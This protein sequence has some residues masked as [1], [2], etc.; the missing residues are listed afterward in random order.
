MF[1]LFLPQKPLRA[2]RL[3]EI[4]FVFI[5]RKGAETAEKY[6]VYFVFT[7]NTFARFA[8][9]REKIVFLF[10]ARICNLLL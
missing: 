9:W 8:P 10:K 4:I 3:S 5:S 7:Q 2:L 1:D 6:K